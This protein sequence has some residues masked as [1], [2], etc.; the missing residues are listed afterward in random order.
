MKEHRDVGYSRQNHYF[1]KISHP[2]MIVAAEVAI[3][4][5]VI[6]KPLG[7]APH[8]ITSISRLLI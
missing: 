3:F 6:P 1:N 5:L 2:V 8:Y 4:K 7:L